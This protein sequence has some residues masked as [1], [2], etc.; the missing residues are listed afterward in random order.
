[1]TIKDKIGDLLKRHERIIIT[2]GLCVLLMFLFMVIGFRVEW[3]KTIGWILPICIII[4][5]IVYALG[6]LLFPS[7]LLTIEPPSREDKKTDEWY[8]K[9]IFD[10]IVVDFGFQELPY[11]KRLFFLKTGEYKIYVKYK[12]KRDEKW[13]YTPKLVNLYEDAHIEIPLPRQENQSES[14]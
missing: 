13:E 12:N 11:Q 1:M 4:C 8:I 14:K 9:I 10:G 2:A 6:F 3:I 7:V 5:I